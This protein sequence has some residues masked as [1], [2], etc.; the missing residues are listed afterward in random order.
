MKK[1]IHTITALQGN[2]AKSKFSLPALISFC[3]IFCFSA[4]FLCPVF[5]FGISDELKISNIYVT[6]ITHK[7]S[8]DEISCFYHSSDTKFIRENEV[9]LESVQFRKVFCFFF[10]IKIMTCNR[11]WES[12]EMPLH[13]CI[14][15]TIRDLGFHLMTPVQ[16]IKIYFRFGVKVIR[17]CFL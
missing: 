3:L 9:W 4:F 15:E 7:T 6:H 16:V 5:F 13:N 2:L 8:P 12:L 1:I 11:K 17:L 10:K 14:L